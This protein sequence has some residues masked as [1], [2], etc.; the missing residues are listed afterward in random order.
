M[1]D[2]NDSSISGT[3]DWKSETVLKWIQQWERMKN[4]SKLNKQL[5]FLT[6]FSSSPVSIWSQRKD[7]FAVI[8]AEL[9]NRMQQINVKNRQ[10]AYFVFV[11][12][13]FLLIELTLFVCVVFCKNWR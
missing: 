3:T 9:A 12:R 1:F 11:R 8:I 13:N 6:I 7:A 5:S 10:V 4:I 2:L